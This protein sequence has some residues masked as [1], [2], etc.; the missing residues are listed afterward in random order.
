M[1]W[2]LIRRKAQLCFEFKMGRIGANHSKPGGKVFR[3]KA[4]AAFESSNART[5]GEDF[6]QSD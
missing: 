4:G 6:L 3:P 5:N 1:K 2:T